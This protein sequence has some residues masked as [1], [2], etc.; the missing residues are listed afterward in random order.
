[1]FTKSK[2]SLLSNVPFQFDR[3]LH[4][5][6][7]YRR[8]HPKQ[9]LPYYEQLITYHIY[10][11]HRYKSERCYLVQSDHY[12]DYAR[13][14]YEQAVTDEVVCIYRIFYTH[15]KLFSFMKLHLGGGV[16]RA[17]HILIESANFNNDTAYLKSL[18]TNYIKRVEHHRVVLFLVLQN[19]TPNELIHRIIEFI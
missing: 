14:I 3:K 4:L 9:V 1:M 6:G 13:D 17:K 15:F 8:L 2:P 18:L 5:L 11:I 7:T 19:K 16:S 10:N 12:N